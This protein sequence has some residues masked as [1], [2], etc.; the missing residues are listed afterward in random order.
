MSDVTD[1]PVAS[2][3]ARWNAAFA[4]LGLGAKP[5]DFVRELSNTIGPPV[6]SLRQV[7]HKLC[8]ERRRSFSPAEAFRSRDA[9]RK[10]QQRKRL[11]EETVPERT[12]R[13][14]AEAEQKA[15]AKVAAANKAEQK[16]KAK[17]AA[18][19][20]AEQKAKAKVAAAN[21]AELQGISKRKE[22]SKPQAR[23]PKAPPPPKVL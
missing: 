14:A 18:A 19:N 4:K 22:E 11:K 8:T 23:K 7:A 17:V 20:K 10:V 16:A 9:E 1:V 2:F 5:S 15:K 13:V 21:K 6:P 3:N 12:E